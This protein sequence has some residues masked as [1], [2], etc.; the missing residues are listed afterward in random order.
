MQKESVE[1][2]E[3]FTNEEITRLK[4]LSVSKYMR[5]INKMSGGH[6]CNDI[7]ANFPRQILLEKLDEELSR[8]GL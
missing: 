8:R 1:R 6:Y 5:E 4:G 7:R 2:F 3:D